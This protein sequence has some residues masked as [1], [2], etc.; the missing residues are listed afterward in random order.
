LL[1]GAKMTSKGQLTLPADLRAELDLEAGDYVEFQ[2]REDGSVIMRAV[3]RPLSAL[4][5]CV[6]YEGPPMTVEQIKEGIVEGATN[7]EGS[8]RQTGRPNRM[9]DAA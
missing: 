5:G 9:N 4:F 7:G 8:K 2:I 6:D 1:F 3:N